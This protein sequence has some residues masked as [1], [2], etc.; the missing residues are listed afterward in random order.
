[1]SRKLSEDEKKR[2]DFFSAMAMQALI[3]RHHGEIQSWDL[4][5]SA[6][7]Y[8]NHLMIELSDDDDDEEEMLS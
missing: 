4:C 1:M 7:R 6:V 8:A 5:A 3:R 2:R